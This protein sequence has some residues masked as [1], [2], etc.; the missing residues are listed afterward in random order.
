MVSIGV[1][2]GRG[3]QES[4]QQAAA[5]VPPRSDLRATC[6][7]GSPP[8]RPSTP[9]DGA[10]RVYVKPEKGEFSE[11]FPDAAY[12]ATTKTTA[13]L[14]CVSEMKKTVVPD[15]VCRYDS[16]FTLEQAEQS[17]QV[18]VWDLV[19]GTKLES[20]ELVVPTIGYCQP[21]IHS[22]ESSPQV[23]ALEDVLNVVLAPHQAGIERQGLI[24]QDLWAVCSGHSVPYAPEYNPSPDAVNRLA[25]FG[26]VDGGAFSHES[27]IGYG[28]EA[29]RG[30]LPEL[31]LCKVATRGEPRGTCK[32]DDGTEVPRFTPRWTYRLFATRTGKVVA[33]K[34]FVTS[35][36]SCDSRW[37]AGS[38]V[39]TVDSEDEHKFIGGFTHSK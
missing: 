22:R 15:D 27:S 9:P 35:K 13:L 3:E 34:E 37:L 18:A 10:A 23:R 38:R 16:G 2:C 17:L 8:V 31:A 6:E 29:P 36:V 14:V 20:Y 1:G 19:A 11:A 32:L 4:S 33:E 25:V 39:A 28:E 26:S 5:K 24:A 12:L 7:T 21:T 30:T